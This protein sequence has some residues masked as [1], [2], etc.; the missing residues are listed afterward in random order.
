MDISIIIVNYNSGD[1]LYNCIKSIQENITGV[2]V[3]VIAVDN[4]SSDNSFTCCRTLVNDRLHLIQSDTNLGFSKANNLAA[5]QAK[6][7]ILHF[8]NPDTRVGIEVSSD[9]RQIIDSTK[10][11]ELACYVNP[12]KNRDGSI[13]YERN[14]Q[15]TP[16]NDLK[17]L[18]ISNSTRYYYIGASIILPREVYNIIGGWNE[19]MFMYG[20]DADLFYQLDRYHIPTVEMPA[21]VYHYGGVSSAKT[22]TGIQHEALIQQSLRTFYRTNHLGLIRYWLLQTMIV[23]SF[24]P[25]FKRMWW[26][27]KAV[28]LGNKSSF[29]W[30]TDNV[31]V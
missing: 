28:R 13:R 14:W 16:E 20:E 17:H 5:K 2:D 9:Y 11:A 23:L 24:F 29:N 8:L 6:G 25:H 3:E 15:L 18:L 10:K 26:Q 7:L 27:M 31:K 12:L 19:A 21:I 4:A 30:Q 22:F 1:F